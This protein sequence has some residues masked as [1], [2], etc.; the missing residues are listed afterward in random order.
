M[1][2]ALLSHDSFIVRIADELESFFH[3]ILYHAARYLPSNC[4]DFTIASYIDGYFDTYG[5]DGSVYVCGDKKANTIKT[6]TLAVNDRKVLKFNSPMDDLLSEVLSWFRAHYL[7]VD[8]NRRVE[9]Q[10]KEATQS[11]EQSPDLEDDTPSLPFALPSLPSKTSHLRRRAVVHD[12]A[13]TEEDETFASYLRVHQYMKDLFEELFHDPRWRPERKRDRIPK[14]WKLYREDPK[15]DIPSHGT[16]KRKIEGPQTGMAASAPVLLV[17]PR[18][19]VTP[20][21]NKLA[22]QSMWMGR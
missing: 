17:R 13:P 20:S 3:V 1:S 2:V 10:P 22:A 18:Q 16:K 14:G 7:V 21:K 12:S 9:K 15:L 19:P 11:G 5:V 4:D 6:G 8:Y